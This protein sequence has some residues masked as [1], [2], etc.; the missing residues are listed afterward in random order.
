MRVHWSALRRAAV[1]L[2]RPGDEDPP[3]LRLVVLHREEGGGREEQEIEHHQWHSLDRKIE[4]T[5]L[6]IVEIGLFLGNFSASVTSLK[7]TAPFE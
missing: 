5:S 2:R 6:F 4:N 1:R 7:G 3:Q